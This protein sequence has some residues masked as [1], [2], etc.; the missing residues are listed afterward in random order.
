MVLLASEIRPPQADGGERLTR[1]AA[2]VGAAG[3]HLGA[4][5]DLEVVL[6]GPLVGSA[7]RLGL[8]AP[9]L[10][11]PLPERALAPGKRLP[12]LSA[13]ESDERGA[14]IALVERG[15]S[16]GVSF[17]ARV[18]LLDFGSVPL[19]AS[20][21]A[22][23]RAF[24][25]REVESDEPGGLLLASALAERRA[26]G[27]EVLDACRWALERLLRSA[28]RASI[29]L[30]IVLGVTPWQ[31]PSPRE[32][33]VLAETFSGSA[34]GPVWDPARLSVLAALGLPLADERCKALAAAAAIAIESDAVGL[35]AGYLPGLGERDSRLGTIVAPAGVPRIVTGGGDATDAE[36]A[37]A[38]E[39]SVELGARPP[40]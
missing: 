24:A 4:G 33:G 14:A 30:A 10:A 29:G 6:G 9:T 21:A 19:A 39:R 11:L 31:A 3:V 28:E 25:R 32:V 8:E 17:G 23:A 12:R 26:R 16:L 15:L 35:D 27:P 22:L 34:F 40:P 7:L 5:C 37:A 13:L 1:L 18:A 2:E 36:V 38:V 20:A